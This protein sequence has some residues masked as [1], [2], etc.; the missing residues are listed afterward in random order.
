[1]EGTRN[2]A[3]IVV[4]G[5]VDRLAGRARVHD[6]DTQDVGAIGIDDPDRDRRRPIQG[7]LDLKCLTGQNVDLG[8]RGDPFVDHSERGRIAG[9]VA[10][11]HDEHVGG[12]VEQGGGRR[13]RRVA[14]VDL[15]R[16][17]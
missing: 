4:V 2:G 14:A 16:G 15:D 3:T 11:N 10:E 1:V 17:A 13:P 12:A 5:G 8:D 6:V 7:Y 9:V